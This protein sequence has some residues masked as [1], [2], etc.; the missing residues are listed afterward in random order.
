MTTQAYLSQAIRFERMTR[1]KLN[2]IQRYKDMSLSTT[3]APKQ[4]VIQSSGSKDKMGTMVAK[5][6]DLEKEVGN[7]TVVRDKI[8]KQIEGLSDPDMY[9]VLYGK[10]IDDCSLNEIARM[11]HLSKTHI[12]RLHDKAL[13]EFEKKYGKYYLDI[14]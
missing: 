6:L 12:Y 7:L 14:K 10:Y 11:I 1:N 3:V 5:I 9:Q 2:E 4:D 13:E 8:I